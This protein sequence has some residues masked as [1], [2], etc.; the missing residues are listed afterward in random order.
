MA[1]DG[2]RSVATEELSYPKL[3]AERPTHFGW[4]TLTEQGRTDTWIA[5]RS[6]LK[7]GSLLELF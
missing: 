6:R 4:V 5:A 1:Q 7:M 2:G 3:E